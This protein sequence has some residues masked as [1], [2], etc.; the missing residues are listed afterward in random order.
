MGF[1]LR[2][3]PIK[4]KLTL[5]ILL[6]TSFALIFMGSAL[7]T[8]EVVTFRRTLA[9]NMSVLAQIVGSNTTAA[10]AFDDPKNAREILGALSAERQITAAAIYDDT[11]NIFA[12][13]PDTDV[14]EIATTIPERPGH[15]G[16]RFHRGALDMFQSISQ[17]EG[18]RLGT[19]F[20]RADLS[21]MYARIGV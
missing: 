12:R 17:Q 18:G 15:D 2:N 16:Y 9:A 10:L 11:G 20:L 6:T 19:I 4:R 21:A 13:F 8:Y 5:F 7:I 14:S 1:S 3:T